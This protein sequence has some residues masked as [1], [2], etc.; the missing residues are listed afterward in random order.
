[1]YTVHSYST[2]LPDHHQHPEDD[3]YPHLVERNVLHIEYPAGRYYIV[4]G[5]LWSDNRVHEVMVFHADKAG[6]VIDWTE[7]YCQRGT[8]DVLTC[9]HDYLTTRVTRNHQ[10]PH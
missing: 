1:M 8:T 7:L 3:K 9:W 6:E 2:D 10:D 4:S 5:V